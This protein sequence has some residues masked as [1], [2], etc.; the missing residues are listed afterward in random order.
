MVLSS[1]VRG[2]AHEAAK[3][4]AAIAEEI[5]T[6]GNPVETPVIVFSGGETTVTLGDDYGRGGPNQEFVLSGALESSVPAVV[7]AVD[8]DGI[9][10]A[11][12]AAGAIVDTNMVNAATASDALSRND[13]FPFLENTDDLVRTGATGTNVN[14]LRILVIE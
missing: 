7:A 5:S 4:H 14:D 2:E 13:A 3:V 10:G 9:D 1:R 12:D 6:T 8:T 11:T